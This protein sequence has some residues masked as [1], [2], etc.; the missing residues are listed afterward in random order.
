MEHLRASRYSYNAAQPVL[1][2]RI[3]YVTSS[4]DH[5]RGSHVE[6]AWVRGWVG[7]TCLSG[8]GLASEFQN[9][10]LLMVLYLCILPPSQRATSSGVLVVCKLLLEVI[11]STSGGRI[12]CT[13]IIVRLADVTCRSLGGRKIRW[14]AG[15]ESPRRIASSLAAVGMLGTDSFPLFNLLST[16]YSIAIPD[17]S[18]HVA[19]IVVDLNLAYDC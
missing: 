5:P 10:S 7:T 17:V 16:I 12:Y 2:G 14:S 8:T 19:L 1:A 9:T 15:S 3:F 11:N 4:T 6:S 13:L 18:W